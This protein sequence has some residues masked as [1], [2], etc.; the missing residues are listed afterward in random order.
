MEKIME[1]IDVKPEDRLV[2]LP[3]R[4]AAEDARRRKDEGMG[5]KGVFCGAAIEIYCP[6]KVIITG[7]NSSLLHA[8]SAAILNATKTIADVPDEIDVISRDVIESII[9]LKRSMGLS[10]TSLDVKEVLDAIAA[11]AVI[12]IN[13]RKCR[14]VLGKLK[15]CEMHT[16]HLMDPGDESPLI[17]LGL[18]VTTDAKL[19]FPNADNK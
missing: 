8:E 1:K 11:S 10:G 3:A 7:K 12:D 15:G 13:A 17:Q 16:T 2:V 14:D 6:D 19:P 18:N 5:Y 4:E 9:Q